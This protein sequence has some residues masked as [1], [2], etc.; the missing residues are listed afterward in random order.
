MSY[1]IIKDERTGEVVKTIRRPKG[2]MSYAETLP[3][4]QRLF[5]WS[6]IFSPLE[7]SPRGGRILA[8]YVSPDKAG[9]GRVECNFEL[10]AV[11]PFTV[12]IQE[13]SGRWSFVDFCSSEKSCTDTASEYAE[14]CATAARVMDGETVI[15]QIGDV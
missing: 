8:V 2:T 3:T 13:E 6:S 4:L 11:C 1:L 10:W 14:R 5:P 9:N 12:E 7:S 15:Y